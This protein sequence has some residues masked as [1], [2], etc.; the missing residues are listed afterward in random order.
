VRELPVRRLATLASWL[1]WMPA[2]DAALEGEPL[3]VGATVTAV[4]PEDATTP[5][6]PAFDADAPGDAVVGV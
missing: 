6:P 3:A 2:S 1:A 5:A 4:C